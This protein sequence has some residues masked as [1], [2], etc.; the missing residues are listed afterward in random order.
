MV[1]SLGSVGAEGI[2]PSVTRP[3]LGQLISFPKLPPAQCAQGSADQGAVFH[4]LIHSRAGPWGRGWAGKRSCAGCC[5][6]GK[7][8]KGRGCGFLAEAEKSHAICD[9]E[10]RVWPLRQTDLRVN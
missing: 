4:L 5:E 2:S 7:A 10:E 9:I 3:D 6:L 8:E 1:T